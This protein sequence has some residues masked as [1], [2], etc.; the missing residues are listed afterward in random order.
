MRIFTVGSND[1]GQRLD[2][3]LTK[4]LPT[5]PKSLMYKYIRTKKIKV[6]RKRAE[7]NTMLSPGDEVQLFIREEF[8]D[9]P[10][11]DTEALYRI[12]PKLSIVY[13]DE[14]IML[15]DKRPGVLVHEDKEGGENTL[16]MHV[17]AYLAQKGE[18][19]PKD[20]L[21][22]APALCNRIDR[23]T[24]GIVI[25]AK[26]ATALRVMNEKIKLGE[27]S[28]FYL[29]AVHGIPKKKS[30]TME[31]YLKKDSAENLVDVSDKY[32]NGYK[33]IITRYKVLASDK[34]IS[35]LEVQL[36]TGRTHQIRAHMAHIGHP[37]LGDG[38]YSVNR[39]DKSRGYKYQALY[40]YRL[41]F[42]FDTEKS[43]TPLDYLAGKEFLVPTENIW[44]LKEFDIKI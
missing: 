38:K 7:Q 6:N 34:G 13:E 24:G 4:A 31:A 11:N 22:F 30:D 15:L 41:I 20:E 16:I 23:N 3:F 43:S 36:L 27:M 18:Y 28:K 42:S 21:S 12:K 8:F 39:E 14:N 19:D 44:F 40:S 2:K 25:A 29:C 10:Q 35:L 37:L 33:K 9:L 1:A 32:V 17:Q 5:L 26:N